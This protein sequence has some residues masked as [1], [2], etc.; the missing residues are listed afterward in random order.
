MV[1]CPQNVRVQRNANALQ[2]ANIISKTCDNTRLC[3]IRVCSRRVEKGLRNLKSGFD[4]RPGRC[5]FSPLSNYFSDFTKR[6][7]MKFRMACPL[8]VPCED[9]SNGV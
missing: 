4:S 7:S 9:S 6:R 3:A 5:Q 2:R 8:F 1:A